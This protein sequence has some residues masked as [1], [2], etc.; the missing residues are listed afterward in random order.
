MDAGPASPRQ[1]GKDCAGR[2]STG[3]STPGH[4]EA[5]AVQDTQLWSLHTP[6]V[7]TGCL[8]HDTGVSA[9]SALPGEPKVVSDLPGPPV[10]CYA[11]GHFSQRTE[12]SH[13]KTEGL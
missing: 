10:R 2:G 1:F 11:R 7:V 12:R 4:P 3:P 5:L 9:T 6:P 8:W 13:H